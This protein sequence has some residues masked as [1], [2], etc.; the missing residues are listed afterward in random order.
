MALRVITCSLLKKN[1]FKRS[2][3]LN[4]V[5]SSNCQISKS[6]YSNKPHS[7]P[8][9]PQQKQSNKGESNRA[10]PKKAESNK[11]GSNKEKVAKMLEYAKSKKEKLPNGMTLSEVFE[12]AISKNIELPEIGG[13]NSREIIAEYQEFAQKLGIDK[14]SSASI[15][16]SKPL[17]DNGS[18]ELVTK[19]DIHND[20]VSKV[21]EKIDLNL[22]QEENLKNVS[23]EI[24]SVF[25]GDEDNQKYYT[26]VLSEA[27]KAYYND[28]KNARAE[29]EREMA[30]IREKGLLNAMPTAYA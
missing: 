14:K 1:S 21:Y 17:M 4:L 9:P 13:K 7:Q 12:L 20:K 22:S 27:L 15:Y 30:P 26:Q 18:S 11:V 2:S 3:N 8:P 28:V 29:Y 5:S 25:A 19:L 6:F 24:K 16:V 10:E 23:S